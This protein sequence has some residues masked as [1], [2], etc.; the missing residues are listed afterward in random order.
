[1]KTAKKAPGKVV[2]AAL[3]GAAEKERKRVYRKVNEIK[4]AKRL[5]A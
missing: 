5:S 4:K 3:P 1:M 2:N